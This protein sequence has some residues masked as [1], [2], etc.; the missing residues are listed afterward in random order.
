LKNKWLIPSKAENTVSIIYPQNSPQ[1][2]PVTVGNSTIT[3]AY[4][5]SKNQT[6]T[7]IKSSARVIR[8]KNKGL[9][10]VVA[11]TDH[12][13][14]KYGHV[15]YQHDQQKYLHSTTAKLKAQCNRRY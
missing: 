12:K 3:S 9:E 15:V 7:G 11:T 8:M 10:H 2:Y 1:P 6:S 5:W 4:I 13:T 14:P